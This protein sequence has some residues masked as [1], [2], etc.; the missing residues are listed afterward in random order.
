LLRQAT[1]IPKTKSAFSEHTSNQTHA[2]PTS[3]F[4]PDYYCRLRS[5]N[6][7]CACALAG[8]TADRELHPAPKVEYLVDVIIATQ[9]AAVNS[10]I[11][12]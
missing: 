3:F 4:Y 10:F 7:S 5:R 11:D 12:C 8:C 1:K 9:I 6:G 2:E